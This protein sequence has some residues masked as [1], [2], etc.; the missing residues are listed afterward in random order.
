MR[1]DQGDTFERMASEARLTQTPEGLVPED[2]GWFVVNIAEARGR[3]H[4]RFGQAVP[5]EGE[6]APFPTFGINVRL[7]QP[8]QPNCYYHRESNPEAFLVLEGECIAIVEERERPMRKGDFLY[9]PP[10]T[11]HVIVG[12]GEGPCAVLMVGTR[13]EAEE[14]EYPVSEVAARHGASV[15]E[16]TDDAGV[17]YAGLDPPQPARFPQ[18]W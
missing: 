8:R 14:L 11:A 2:G 16:A 6:Q 10:G 5:F 7:L 13:D 17:A 3:R 12:A 4:E 1:L 18:P 9:A 15:Q